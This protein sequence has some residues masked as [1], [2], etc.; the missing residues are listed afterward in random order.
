MGRASAHGEAAGSPAGA[1]DAFA[2][3]FLFIF[4]VSL[5]AAIV[6]LSARS[7]LLVIDVC[8]SCGAIGG[9]GCAPAPMLTLR[10][11]ALA[12]WASRTM[13][14]TEACRACTSTASPN[15]AEE[16]STEPSCRALTGSRCEE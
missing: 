15:G 8:T 16:H 14:C 13:E 6:T 3:R 12:H 1:A 2:E 5:I 7:H 4:V 10:I 9:S 11:G